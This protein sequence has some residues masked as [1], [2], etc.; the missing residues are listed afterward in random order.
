MTAPHSIDFEAAERIRKLEA[1]AAR[2]GTPGEGVAARAALQRIRARFQAVKRTVNRAGKKPCRCGST[3]FEVEPAR[4]PHAY[5]LR[6]ANCARGGMWMSF[7]DARQ[8]DA[9]GAAAMGA[10]E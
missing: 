2:P 7:A 1:L 3:Q 4:G 6:C 9:D 8:F 5:H 10:K